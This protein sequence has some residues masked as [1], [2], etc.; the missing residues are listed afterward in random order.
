M[1]DS[2]P[3]P[4]QAGIKLT[5][6][7]DESKHS[8]NPRSIAKKNPRSIAKNEDQ[9]WIDFIIRAVKVEHLSDLLADI[10]F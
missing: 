5:R 6:P 3:F 8:M 9:T 4:S 2:K 1:S 10:V 7:I